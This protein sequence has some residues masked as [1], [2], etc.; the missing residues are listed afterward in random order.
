MCRFS[1]TAME[2]EERFI[3]V[4]SAVAFAAEMLGLDV[5]TLAN[6]GK[7]VA[8]GTSSRAESVLVAA[9]AH[10]RCIGRVKKGRGV[11][12]VTAGGGRRVLEVPYGEDAPRIC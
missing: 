5:L 7:L 3:P 9:G 1:Y 12:L 4:D 6:E 2:I 8:Q 11:T 10:P